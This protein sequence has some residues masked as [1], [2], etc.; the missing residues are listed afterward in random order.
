M[1]SLD[2]ILFKETWPLSIKIISSITASSVICTGIIAGAQYIRNK[3]KRNKKIERC[4]SLYKDEK[5]PSDK[6]KDY[7]LYQN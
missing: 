4:P 6:I 2:S 5:L 3:I 1:I 7:D